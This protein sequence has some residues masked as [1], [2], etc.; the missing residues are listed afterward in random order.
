[1]PVGYLSDHTKTRRAPFLFGLVALTSAT[2]LLHRGQS[3]AI[4]TLARALQGVS[5]AIVWSSGLALLADTVS[6]SRIGHVMGYMYLAMSLGLLSGPLLGGVLFEH[7]GYD[8]VFAAAYGLIGVDLILRLC[9][10]EKKL[11]TRWTTARVAADEIN[12]LQ[13]GHE[14]W[15]R[16]IFNEHSRRMRQEP[17]EQGEG[18]NPDPSSTVSRR[19]PSIITLLKSTRFLVS[20]WASTV[21]AI[22]LTS[23]D[24]VLPLYAKETFNWNSQNAGLLFLAPVVPSL[25][26]PVVGL[27]SDF[28]GPKWVATSGLLL[29]IVVEVLFRLV[30]YNTL[31]QKVLLVALLTLLGMATDLIVTPIMADITIVVERKNRNGRFGASGA[32]AQAYGLLN[33]AYA[34]GALIGPV[35]G[36]YVFKIWGLGTM[37][38]TF[39]LICAATVVPTVIWCGGKGLTPKED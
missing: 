6:P 15:G 29:A 9:L 11:A 21:F 26:G 18:S 31:N 19:V 25:L 22:L 7:A 14:L 17:V 30:R 23:L 10:V 4:L 16:T 28:F 37:G 36:G 34:I 1:V 8:A 32:Y 24:A 38:W 33:F 5:A 39:S 2:V 13:Q 3:I 35:W 12:N 27:A 20:L